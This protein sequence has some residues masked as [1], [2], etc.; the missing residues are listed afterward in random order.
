MLWVVLLYILLVSIANQESHFLSSNYC[1]YVFVCAYMQ[2][3][4]CLLVLP[5]EDLFAL[6]HICPNAGLL[7]RCDYATVY[8]C[9]RRRKKGS[10]IAVL[11]SSQTPKITE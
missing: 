1:R 4:K 2:E 3:S 11:C 5:Q 10:P 7:G 9:V 8:H 6:T